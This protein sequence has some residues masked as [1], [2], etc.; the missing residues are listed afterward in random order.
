MDQVSIMSRY[1][2]I[3]ES[4]INDCLNFKD[5]V[6]SPFRS[7]STPSLSFRYYRGKLICVDF[8]DARTRGDIFDIA[9]LA[10]GKNCNNPD[11]FVYICRDIIDGGIVNRAPVKVADR[12]D[13]PTQIGFTTRAFT[14]RDLRY[15]WQYGINS[16]IVKDNYYA[17][18]RYSINDYESV[19]RH[20]ADDPCYA[21][22]NNPNCVKLYFPSRKHGYRFITNNK[23]PIECITS[24]RK[25]KHMIFIKAFKDKLLMDDICAILGINDVQFLPVA[26][27]TARLSNTILNAIQPY[28]NKLFTMFDADKTGEE[29][30]I[31]YRDNYNII[32]LELCKDTGAKDPTDLVK[33]KGK[34]H[35]I[36]LFKE[37]YECF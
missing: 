24:I 9:S 29:S 22:Y 34:N 26:S 12:E 31:Y 15:F 32:N 16:E 17:V 35:V 21:Y 2:G 11:D 33:S 27:E 4:D 5:K 7:D 37:L 1:L 36:K 18:S 3:S 14:N 10:L 23:F 8:G 28:T 6:S 30:A 13:K 19:Y 25:C 20:T